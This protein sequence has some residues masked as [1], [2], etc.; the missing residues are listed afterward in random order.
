M[1]SYE[2]IQPQPI[3]E[4]AIVGFLGGVELGLVSRESIIPTMGQI[5]QELITTGA[6]AD[7]S[8]LQQFLRQRNAEIQLVAQPFRQE[9]MPRQD[10]RCVNIVSGEPKSYYMM[11]SVGPQEAKTQL[12]LLKMSDEVNEATLANDTGFLVI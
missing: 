2:Q 10:I 11:V 9:E 8:E 12:Q 1:E 4:G 7:L 5:C 3:W 6:L